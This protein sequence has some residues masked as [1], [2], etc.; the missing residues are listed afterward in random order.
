MLCLGH[1]VIS[2]VRCQGFQAGFE[3]M[4][5]WQALQGT[6]IEAA[7]E[8]AMT[9]RQL[10]DTVPLDRSRMGLLG[11][12]LRSYALERCS[13]WQLL[14]GHLGRAL[15]FGCH[16]RTRCLNHYDLVNWLLNPSTEA[17]QSAFNGVKRCPPP[18][19][20]SWNWW[21]GHLNRWSC[22]SP[23]SSGRVP[24]TGS[25]W[26]HSAAFDGNPL[27]RPIQIKCKGI[28]TQFPNKIL[29]KVLFEVEIR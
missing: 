27:A 26:P 24:R 17:T 15:A 25:K 5:R 11:Y 19:V 7:D 8:R 16:V 20:P 14:P 13:S 3:F 28:Q 10:S 2:I 6:H 12:G 4:L 1:E 23:T 9:Y 21:L 22:L 18:E 29:L